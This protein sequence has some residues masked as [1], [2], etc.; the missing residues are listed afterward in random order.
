DDVLRMIR[1]EEP[2]RPSNRLSGSGDALPAISARRGTEPR[3]LTNAVRGE[4]DW[5]VMKC[6]EKDRTRRYATA[7]DLARDL[8]RYLADEPVEAGPP[9]RWYRL[10]KLARR[11]RAAFVTAG[12]FAALLALAAALSSWQAWREMLAKE[13]YRKE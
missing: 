13:D 7:N 5:I 1:E 4:L 9:S 11:H 8:Q 2:P 12:A 10:R 3:T 6:L